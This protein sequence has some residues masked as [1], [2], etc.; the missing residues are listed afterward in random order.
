[1]R[2]VIVNEPLAR[3]LW[4][5]AD[6]IG[7]R[8][9]FSGGDGTTWEQP[10][11]V[12]GVVRGV[13]QGLF[14][15]APVPQAFVPVADSPLDG[16]TYFHLRIAPRGPSEATLL[17]RVR[18]QL[19]EADPGLAVIS[20]T[21]LSDHRDAS[22]YLGMARG[23]AEIFLWFG[24]AALGLATLGVYG[25]KSFLVAQ[26]T[27]EIGIRVA[28]GATRADILRLVLGEGMLWTTAAFGA[29]GA[30]AL[31][32]SRVLASWV[33]GVG[34]GDPVS[35]VAAFVVLLAASLLASYLPAR[36]AFAVPPTAALR[37]P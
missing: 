35:L 4:P 21:T 1:V 18:Q 30:L 6:P 26:R 37:Q 32:L 27:G 28:L 29:G 25:V 13:R 23:S 34:T 5:D 10:R 19:R 15:T 17:E 36:R 8:V 33:Y 31:A 12:V 16:E 20:V 3:D 2:P 11:E 7:Q 24:L 22:I 9:Q 14:D